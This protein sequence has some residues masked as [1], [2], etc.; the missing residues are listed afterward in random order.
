MRKFILL[1]LFVLVN[2][3]LPAQNLSLAQLLEIKKKDLGNAIE[4][5]TLEGWE[6]FEA[7]APTNGGLG[8]VTFSYNK[9][10][11]SSTADSFFIYYYT[12]FPD[13]TW[14]SIQ[15]SKINKYNEYINSIKE[16]GCELISTEVKEGRILKE[17]KGENMTFL[18]EIGKTTNHF[19][20]ETAVW[21]LWVFSTADYDLIWGVK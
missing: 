8:K 12:S 14:I 2:V 20:E 6:F 17:Y 7:E 5:L 11:L 1:L 4:Y 16:Y 15:V 13:M 19:D 18:V 9:S 21:H 3:A 10:A